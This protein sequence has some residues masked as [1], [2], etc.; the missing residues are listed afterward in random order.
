MQEGC[1]QRDADDA[2]EEIAD[3]QAI[4]RGIVAPG[5]LE[6]RVDGAAEIGPEHQCHGRIGRDEMRIGQR[7]HQQHARDAGMH[8]PGDGGAEDDAQRDVGG[9][10]LHEHAHRRRLLGRRERVDQDMERQQHQAEA[11]RH[12]AEIL[13]ARSRPAAERHQAEHE[14]DRRDGRDVERQHLDDQR[15]A[16]IGAQ[17]DRHRGDQADEAFRSKGGGDERRCR[18]ALEKRGEAE[19]GREGA[20]TVPQRSRQ[21]QPEIRAEG[22]QDAAVD[23]VKAPQQQR[24]AT[25][26]IEQNHDS[27]SFP[28]VFR[29]RLRPI[30][31][32]STPIWR[33][34][35]PDR[36]AL[37]PCRRGQAALNAAKPRSRSALRSS[38][39]S[40]PMCSRNVGPPGAH[41]VAVR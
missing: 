41:V 29:P 37:R 36:A 1:D 31:R 3:G 18:A 28:L 10:R 38:V 27:R 2:V 21:Q 22:A 34:R 7:H 20:E 26:Q 24:H 33:P 16:D 12:P 15:G 11:D 30:G 6:H 5:A 13:D 35:L 23:H 25:H 32:G 39:F 40:R 14:Q 4:A 17:H 9:D 19:S 8:D